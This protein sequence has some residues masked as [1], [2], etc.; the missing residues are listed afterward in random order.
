M[1]E[2]CHFDV[3]MGRDAQPDLYPYFL[4]PCERLV[5]RTG[6]AN[7][8]GVAGPAELLAHRGVPFRL[9]ALQ[10]VLRRVGTGAL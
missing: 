7:L 5:V 1:E 3:R 2:Y 6:I 9:R 4:P 10:P 8:D